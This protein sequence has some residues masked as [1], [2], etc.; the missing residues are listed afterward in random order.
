MD[1]TFGEVRGFHITRP[2]GKVESL[3]TYQYLLTFTFWVSSGQ[4]KFS[5][6]RPK[7][8]AASIFTATSFWYL[9]TWE[10]REW[11][12]STDQGEEFK[13]KTTSHYDRHQILKTIC[14]EGIR[15][16]VWEH[17]HVESPIPSVQL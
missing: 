17:D 4:V 9:L 6:T 15:E 13:N 11:N 10:I 3:A 16:N 1:F 7:G 8:P 14:C 12:K 2:D 5:V